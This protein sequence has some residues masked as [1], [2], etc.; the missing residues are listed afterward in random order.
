MTFHVGQKVVFVG[1]GKRSISRAQIDHYKISVPRLKATYT[2]E[3]VILFEGQECLRL[4]ELNNVHVPTTTGA[5]LAFYGFVFRPV[6]E[7]KTDI[8]IFQAMLNPSDERVA[9]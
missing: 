8:S 9:V 2:V 7:R 1:G 5:E 6:V 3:S 4:V